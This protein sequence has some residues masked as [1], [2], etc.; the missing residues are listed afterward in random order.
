MYRLEQVEPYFPVGKSLSPSGNI[1]IHFVRLPFVFKDDETKT[2]E[3]LRKIIKE[4]FS[5]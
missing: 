2:K 5:L 1:N 3:Q 4:L